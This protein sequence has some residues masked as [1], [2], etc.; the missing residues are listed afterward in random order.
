MLIAQKAV[1]DPAPYAT[2]PSDL[3][4]EYTNEYRALQ[5]NFF[6][7]EKRK[8]GSG[9]DDPSRPDGL[10]K[11]EVSRLVHDGK[12]LY[13]LGRS[14]EA[15]VRLNEA[16]KQDP[17]NQA[18]AY[19]LKLLR[20]DRA[21][22]LV[23]DAKLLYE[24]GRLEGAEVELKEALKEDTQEV[25]ANYYLKLLREKKDR[26]RPKVSAP[27]AERGRES[28]A[29]LQ[30]LVEAILT[31]DSAG[32]EKE[33]L[34]FKIQLANSRAA[35]AVSKQMIG[36]QAATALTKRGTNA[37][38]AVP[39]LLSAVTNKDMSVG[40]VTAEALVGIRAEESPEW[41][42]SRQM[43]TGQT[44]AARVF[45]HLVVG[46]DMFGRTYD[47]AHRRFG[48]LGLAATGPAAGIA[49][50]DIVEVLK[51]DKDLELRAC[52]AM[53]LGGLEAERMATMVLL[54]G[55]LQ[56]KEEWPL[57]SAAAAKVLVT[58]APAEAET[59]DLLR[60]ALQDPRS[61]VRLADARA[62]WRMPAPADE[63]LRVL[64]ALLNNKLV[65]TRAGALNGLCEMGSAARPSVPEVQRLT[66]YP[67]TSLL[68]PGAALLDCHP[69]HFST[70]VSSSGAGPSTPLASCLS[71]AATSSG[72]STP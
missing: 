70:A 22:M 60:Q 71:W 6:L 11:V 32:L 47:A 10:S 41:A 65:S 15:E 23:N 34:G 63:V 3:R 28:A 44:N 61:A 52:A 38:P 58:A 12:L 36:W 67:Q 18:A 39:A 33:G 49:Y 62:L 9:T 55:V 27:P 69:P 56:D 40:V 35:M 2:W 59:R 26:Q 57:V 54:K 8:L 53:V 13:E 19:Y 37:W 42:R 66:T 68:P 51:H 46:R 43:L 20:Q 72:C 21:N 16:L 5:L 14:S 48:L 25:R 29:V 17:Q 31:G 50:S 45:R 30:A 64:T 7:R 4:R 1:L 24:E